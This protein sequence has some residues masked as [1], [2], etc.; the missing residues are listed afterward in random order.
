MLNYFV[1]LNFHLCGL[2]I[3]K[4]EF[5]YKLKA[6][7][8]SSIM[9]GNYLARYEHIQFLCL[10]SMYLYGKYFLILC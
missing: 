8:N 5:L 6:V 3:S 9:V 2:K 1:H 10:L 7:I 4:D